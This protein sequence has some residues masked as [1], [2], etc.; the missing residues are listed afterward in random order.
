MACNVVV[1][2]V[3]GGVVEFCAWLDCDG[4]FDDEAEDVGGVVCA[5]VVW[6]LAV[7]DGCDG[8]T[9][10]AAATAVNTQLPSANAMRMAF[11]N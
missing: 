7:G 2:C 5:L 11:S 9:V 6:V 10:C 4:V 3:P 8:V 1:C